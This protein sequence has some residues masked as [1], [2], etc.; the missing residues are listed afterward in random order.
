V[1]RTKSM[2]PYAAIAGVIALTSFNTSA[3]AVTYTT[4]TCPLCV[5]GPV[6]AKADFTLGNGTV[7]VTLTDLLANPTSA[8]Q[9][10][11]GIKFDVSGA[12][13]SGSLARTVSN[14]LVT[15]IDIG[16]DTFSSPVTD[17][18]T[19]WKASE[20]GITI[21]LTTLSGGNPDRLIIGPPDGSNKYTNA[22]NSVSGDNPNVVGS[23][24]FT[25][26]IPGVK[27]TSTLSSIIFLFGTTPRYGDGICT[28]CGTNAGDPPPV[29][30]PIPA[31]LWL[32]GS[33][34][35]GTVGVGKWRRRQKKAARPALRP[36]ELT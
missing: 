27:D 23:P 2:L 24:T 20:T 9:L 34:L 4:T 5:D 18:L 14:N 15:T 35:A 19:R 25:I 33:V 3:G 32:F 7:A 1:K 36:I 12:N 22:N 13:G 16:N 6:S 30:T 11:S 29:P 21:T 10:V 17:P 26:T 28:S 8:G 31:A